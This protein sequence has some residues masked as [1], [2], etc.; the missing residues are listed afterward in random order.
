MTAIKDPVTGKF[1]RAGG[2]KPEPSRRGPKGR[3]AR[4]DDP[5]PPPSAAREQIDR[6]LL[7]LDDARMP[8]P[9]DD[10]DVAFTLWAAIAL[11]AF[12]VVL[13]V[14]WTGSHDGWW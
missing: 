13:L 12:L 9:A 4:K 3:F 14:M 2:P 6:I 1:M 11:M 5:F 7:G 8:S 10:G